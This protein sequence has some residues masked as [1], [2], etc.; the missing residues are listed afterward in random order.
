ME[1]F[2]SWLS[3]A[4]THALGWAL[5]HSLWQRLAVVAL[6]AG[7]M[8]LCRRPN[9]RY[10]VALG[11]LVLTGVAPVA[12]FFVLM[13]PAAPVVGLLSAG[14]ASFYATVPS[15]PV[16]ST[17]ASANAHQVAALSSTHARS[18]DCGFRGLR[19]P[20]SVSRRTALAGGR[21]ASRRGAVELAIGW[22]IFAFG[23]QAAQQIRCLESHWPCDV[24]GR[25]AATRFGS[26]HSVSAM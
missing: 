11:A 16:P 9:I 12:M 25:A 18:G 23:A 10:L 24:P 20:L 19:L 26:R 7:L 2:G 8:A 5:I 4:I 22:R 15:S 17:A 3:P 1:R 14:P 6:A 21:V 13:Q